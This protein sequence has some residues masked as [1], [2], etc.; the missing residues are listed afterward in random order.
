MYFPCAHIKNIIL[1]FLL[2][3]ALFTFADNATNA[4][5]DI[6]PYN[7]VLLDTGLNSET[8][9]V[10]LDDLKR[11]GE[12]WPLLSTALQDYENRNH[13]EAELSFLKL[14]DNHPDSEIAPVSLFLAAASAFKAE[15]YMRAATNIVTLVK[16]YP[17][18]RLIPQ[19]RLIQ[20]KALANSAR[21]KD[22]IIVLDNLIEAY[23]ESNCIIEAAI[24]RGDA[25]H[26]SSGS[27]HNHREASLSY[28][29][30][31]SNIGISPALRSY[32]L[33]RMAKCLMEDG[34]ISG[35]KAALDELAKI[36]KH[37]SQN[38][39]IEVFGSKYHEDS[40][41]GSNER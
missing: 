7:S 6:P 4:A 2:T 27:T 12:I 30:A 35:A 13:R 10:S 34:D 29:M 38:A 9:S 32:A 28:A 16:K 8:N 22:V 15:E 21:F 24:L 14:A 40:K 17:S 1:F 26:S 18:H 25:L 39:Y 31:L 36:S 19:G 23:P 41:T 20:A 37:S 33:R 5:D 11:E 3:S